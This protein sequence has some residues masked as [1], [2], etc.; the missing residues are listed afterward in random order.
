MPEGTGVRT[1]LAMNLKRA[2][3]NRGW[4]QLRLATET[5]LAH[6]F[7]N[8][9]EQGKK[10]VSPDSLD[11]LCTALQIEPYQL[12]SPVESPRVDK[13]AAVAGLC[14]ELSQRTALLVEELRV[15][16]LSGS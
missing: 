13:D 16:Y 4:S 1:L 15:K 10:W 12:F 9:I 7:I 3:L 6:N 8:N 5:G 14:D 11:S 2:R